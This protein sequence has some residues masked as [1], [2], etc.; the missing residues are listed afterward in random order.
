LASCFDWGGTWSGADRSALMNVGKVRGGGEHNV[1][2]S[3]YKRD[4][5]GNGMV[6][7]C[8]TR[9][10]EVPADFCGEI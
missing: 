8:S 9:G 4:V 2:R 1:S 5:K 6:R 3:L 10:V 7:D